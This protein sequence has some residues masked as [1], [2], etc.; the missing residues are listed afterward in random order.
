MKRILILV[1]M[2]MTAGVILEGQ[3]VSAP[4]DQTSLD[5]SGS[6]RRGAPGGHM[7]RSRDG[8]ASDYQEKIR[9]LREDEAKQLKALSRESGLTKEQKIVRTRQIREA[10]RAKIKAVLPPEQRAK[11][12]ES[13]A[14]RTPPQ[15]AVKARG[16]EGRGTAEGK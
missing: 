11:Y 5:A 16:A 1:M 10:T 12:E 4:S 14:K 8:N 3:A 2:L 9:K 15:E 6:R 7:L 13:T